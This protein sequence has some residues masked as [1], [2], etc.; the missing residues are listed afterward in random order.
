MD[1]FK[2]LAFDPQ[3][4][5]ARAH[6]KHEM[7][8]SDRFAILHRDGASR[9]VDCRG[10]AMDEVD[11]MIDEKFRRAKRQRFAIGLAQ[12]ER[13]GQR[14]ALIGQSRLITDQGNAAFQLFL[15]QRRGGLEPRMPGADNDN[16]LQHRH[17]LRPS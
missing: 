7:I 17:L 2:I 11:A 14:G 1:P 6:R 12:H 4:A 8:V 9:A 15:P 10:A 16:R 3:R 5:I 13:L